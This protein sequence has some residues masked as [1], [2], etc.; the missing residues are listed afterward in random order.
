MHAYEVRKGATT[1]TDLHKVER[2][3]PAPGPREVLI[4]VRA[5]SLNYRDQMVVTGKYFVPV[6][7]DMVPLSD[8]AGE[9]VAIG[10]EVT[11]FKVGDRVAGTFLQV[12]TDG[13]RPREAEALGV[14]LD[15]VL[16]EYIV[17]PEQGVVTIPA[18]LSYEE[19]ATLPCA[20]VTA[21]NALMVA[22]HAVKPGD[23]VLCLGT[24][25][26]ST[27]GLQFGR[28]AGARVIVTSSS[29]EKLARVRE[30]G[31]NDVIN[32]KRTPD[33][34]KEVE[35]LTDGRGVDHVVEIGGAGTLHRSFQSLAFG[36]KVS[37]IG[38]LGGFQGD[39]NPFPLM[40][41]GGSLHGIGVGSTRMFELMN[42]AID[43]NRIRPIV[44]RVF[45][46][47]EAPSAFE[48]FASRDFVGKIVIRM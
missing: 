8:G 40:M 29:D 43:V 12:W 6:D 30:A 34:E 22:G 31:A 25:G 24:G 45:P 15:G 27:F 36:G 16:A 47:D 32:Y 42:A 48:A 1:L 5:A 44:D 9:V 23:T 26:V 38:F 28:A 4:R 17:L 39:T 14:P 13:P 41:K 10:P 33:W 46:F 19:A 21:W 2:P 20:G 37:L 11:R 35:R 3:D 18:S 7:R